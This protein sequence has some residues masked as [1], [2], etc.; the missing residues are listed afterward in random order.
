LPAG[1]AIPA[2]T[3]S[4]VAAVMRATLLAAVLV[5][6]AGV[7]VAAAD[8]WNVA[9]KRGD[10]ATAATLLQR[11]VFERTPSQAPDPAALKQLALL[12]GEGKGV[13]RDVIMACGL[14]RAH[15]TAT[16]GA[17]RGT[18]AARR[19]ADALV[20]RY[21]TALTA[22]QRA[23]AVA[24]TACPRIGLKRGATMALEPGWA[25]QF[26]DRSATITRHG[27]S[28]E[29]PLAGGPLCGT[30]VIRVRH[31]PLVA[32]ATSEGLRHL[33]EFVTVQSTWRN[34]AVSREVVWQL[35]EVRGLELDLAAVQRWPE[36][37]SA[38]PAPAL[39]APLARGAAFTLRR[40][41]EIDYDIPDD[42]ARRGTVA[43]RH[44]K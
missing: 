8:T 6:G 31:T 19:A 33:I 11:A 7:P 35:Y 26:N 27:L 34:T 18:A 28:R 22:P 30:Q 14:S 12:Y 43:V 4:A 44:T 40:S 17:P 32:A 5:V 10:Y 24:A 41:G 20:G 16:A 1:I 3:E 21:C 37:G 15:A 9:Y 2:G 36:P 42:P 39:P 25:I 38:W 23:A 29:Q 13:E